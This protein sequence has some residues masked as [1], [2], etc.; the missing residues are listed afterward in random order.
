MSIAAT[1]KQAAAGRSAALR[2]QGANGAF[3]LI[4]LLVVIA[5]ISLLVSIIL[6]SLK[7]AK[8]L[9]RRSICGANLHNQHVAMQ[10]YVNQYVTLPPLT[11]SGEIWYYMPVMFHQA[12]NSGGGRYTNFGLLWKEKCTSEVGLFY[13]PSQTDPAFLFSTPV[14]PWPVEDPVSLSGLTWAKHWNDTFASYCR[15]LGLKKVRYDKF[16]PGM[17]VVSDVAMFPYYE[18]TNHRSKGFNVLYASGDVWFCTDISF[19]EGPEYWNLGLGFDGLQ[20]HCKELFR[21]LDK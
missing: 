14:N 5:I 13:C 4:E 9:A 1:Q 20:E 2:R 8:E 17:A 18:Q 15:R 21:R 11:R 6:P 3:T 7:K 16:E 10:M 12:S 19:R